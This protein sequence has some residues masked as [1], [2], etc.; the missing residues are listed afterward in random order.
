MLASN[1]EEEVRSAIES[2]PLL[3]PSEVVPMLEDRVRSGL[4]RTLLDVAIDSLLLL[5]DKSSS[6]LLAELAHHRRAEV[7]VRAL[8]SLARMKAPLARDALVTGLG[9]QVP[10]V[11]DASAAGLAE[12]GDRGSIPLLTR[13]FEREVAGA[14]AALGR[15]AKAEDLNPLLES[16]DRYSLDRWQ[17]FFAALLARRDLPEADKL[18]ALERLIARGGDDTA[19]ALASLQSGAPA[20]TSPRVKKLLAD[21]IQKAQNP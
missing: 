7:R 5:G 8:E 9:D 16:L 12:L 18:R 11:R 17:P 4:S 20:D 15:L 10:E 13:A 3:P 21:A 19:D 2:A 1:D 6:A 14:A